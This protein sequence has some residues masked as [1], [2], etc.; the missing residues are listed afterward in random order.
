MARRRSHPFSLGLAL[1]F[2]SSLHLLRREPD[3]LCPL[4]EEAIE[5]SEL[6]REW[7]DGKIAAAEAAL[8]AAGEDT[9]LAAAQRVN[10]FKAVADLL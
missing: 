6:N 1:C 4:A 2:A 5:K 3:R 10:D 9:R 8:E 7:I